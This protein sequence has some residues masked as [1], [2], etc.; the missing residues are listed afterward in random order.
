MNRLL[1]PLCSGFSATPRVEAFTFNARSM[2]VKGDGITDDTQA[3][4]VSLDACAGM[5]AA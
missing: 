2:G 1:F 4:Q 5:V 3:L